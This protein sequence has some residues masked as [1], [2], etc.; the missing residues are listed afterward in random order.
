MSGCLNR[1]REIN[2]QIETHVNEFMGKKLIL[3]DS[4]QQNYC[5]TQYKNN[6]NYKIVTSLDGDCSCSIEALTKWQ[7]YKTSNQLITE[8]VE[9]IVFLTSNSEILLHKD[10]FKEIAPDICLVFDQGNLYL[11][12]NN[13]NFKS[14]NL[15]TFLLD[16]TNTVVLIG[17]PLANKKIYTLYQSYLSNL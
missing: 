1:K 16:N 2:S 6:R 12:M 8:N 11:N 15:A 9:V 14:N 3:Y 4:L 5:I 17:N 7:N 10:I 13:L